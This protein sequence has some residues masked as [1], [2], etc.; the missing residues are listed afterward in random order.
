[1]TAAE[2]AAD[3]II[4]GNPT[5]EALSDQ[6][7]SHTWQPM[8]RGWKLAFSIT[9]AGTLMLAALITLTVMRGIGEWGNNIPAAWGF[10]IIN[11]VWWIGIGHAGTFISAIL[12]VLEQQQVRTSI[13]RFTEGMTLFAVV[14]AGFV[15]L[16]ACSFDPSTAES[17]GADA[18]AIA[19]AA[20][21]AQTDAP[22]VK[23]DAQP[24]GPMGSDCMMG[25]I[26]F[27]GGHHC[28]GP[29]CGPE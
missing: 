18:T 12:L 17:P 1:M 11:F 13:N 20:V 4:I 10:G 6:L 26:G 7:L 22:T 21:T 28:C 5:D 3:P 2:E 16:A 19:D 23:M 27:G 24:F 15:F 14:Q 9:G 8:S 29:R 25:P